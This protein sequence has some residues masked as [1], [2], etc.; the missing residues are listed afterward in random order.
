MWARKPCLILLWAILGILGVSCSKYR[1]IEKS[2]DWRIKYEAAVNYFEKKDYYH[3]ALLLEQIRP[4]V[5]GLPEGEK[6][7][8]LLAYCQY[9]EGT[10]LLASSQFKSFYET[11]GRSSLAEEAH[12]MYAYS[13]YAS[14]PEYNL[15][16]Q[17][18][19]EAMAAMQNFLNQYPNSEYREQAS[20]VIA[21]SQQKL[22]LKNYENSKLYLKLRQYKA[23]L[24][25]FDSFMQNF[26]DSKYLEEI[27]YLKVEA[28]F[29]LASQSLVKLQKERFSSVLELHKELIDNYPNSK[30]LRDSE[31]YY[32]E[33]LSRVN[34]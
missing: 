3:S 10:Y 6:V 32:S 26:P 15:D 31:K 7:E 4:I 30:Y 2:Q 11:Y 27:T 23:A 21:E 12:F 29:K 16:Q 17:S 24:V 28:Q 9:N 34:N 33:S 1:K 5:R 13:L 20:Q 25:A 19:K 14:S 22:E 18:S 8:Y